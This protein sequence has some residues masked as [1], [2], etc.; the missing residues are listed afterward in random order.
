MLLCDC[1]KYGPIIMG[2]SGIS[3]SY[4]N[5]SSWPDYVE[6]SLAVSSNTQ[7]P[8]V[9]PFE[10]LLFGSTLSWPQGMYRSRQKHGKQTVAG[11]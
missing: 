10:N 2:S 3:S 4:Y 5:T 1:G 8:G 6:R 7:D 9:Y 11:N